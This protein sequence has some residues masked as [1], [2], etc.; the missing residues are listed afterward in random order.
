MY[1]NEAV[2][3]QLMVLIKTLATQIEEM[4]KAI[5]AHLNKDAEV[6]KLVEGITLIKGV[7]VLTVAIVLAE[8]NGFALLKNYSSTY[9]L[10]RV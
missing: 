6:A 8:T 2:I 5:V 1:Q 10:C 9:K 3:S 7:G 4:E